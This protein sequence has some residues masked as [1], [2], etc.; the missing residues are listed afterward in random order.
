ML[1]YGS[2]TT[3]RRL[4]TVAGTSSVRQTQSRV[5]GMTS[6]RSLCFWSAGTTR[7]PWYCGR[8][9][10]GGTAGPQSPS[11]LGTRTSR[12]RRRVTRA[13]WLNL[14]CSRRR[15]SSSTVII[16]RGSEHTDKAETDREMRRQ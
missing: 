16:N 1:W 14:S 6:T 11:E 9:C 3:P 5:S 12:R 7:H 4:W 8:T 13:T 15:W 2:F 10:S